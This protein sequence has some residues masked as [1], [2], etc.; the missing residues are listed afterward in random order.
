MWF[1]ALNGSPQSEQHQSS[2]FK[3]SFKPQ[4]RLLGADADTA[5]VHLESWAPAIG[6]MNENLDSKA[7]IYDTKCDEVQSVAPIFKIKRDLSLVRKPQ[8]HATDA[9]ALPAPAKS[10]FPNICPAIITQF[11]SRMN[12]FERRNNKVADCSPPYELSTTMNLSLTMDSLSYKKLL[13]RHKSEFAS[14]A[15][16]TS[17]AMI[18]S[19]M[20]KVSQLK[21]K[22]LS[23]FIDIY[24]LI[25]ILICF[26]L[27]LCLI[28]R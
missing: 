26:S 11:L 12:P 28:S 7:V 10:F 17:A 13:T 22:E 24:L 20:K 5:T 18:S 2:I 27:L 23:H 8:K 25:N 9:T 6:N 4:R 1:F 21:L 15:L 3:N 16:K 14:F 19:H